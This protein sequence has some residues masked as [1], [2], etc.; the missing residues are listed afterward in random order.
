MQF[1]QLLR[2]G[3]SHHATPFPSYSARPI[4]EPRWQL[5]WVT[6]ARAVSPTL[7]K[8]C[9]ENSA[10]KSIAAKEIQAERL[11]VSPTC[12]EKPAR[13]IF[14]QLPPTPSRAKLGACPQESHWMQLL[15]PP[16]GS[17][18]SSP[19]VKTFTFNPTQPN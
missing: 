11:E 1:V 18:I 3:R 19:E 9:P 17:E 8:A 13:L 4:T 12:Q 16:S 7:R 2:I 10:K 6:I 15:P 5:W 14:K